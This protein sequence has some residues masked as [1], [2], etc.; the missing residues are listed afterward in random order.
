MTNSIDFCLHASTL[1][2]GP[3]VKHFA[4]LC[5]LLRPE[6]VAIR[7]LLTLLQL[8]LSTVQMISDVGRT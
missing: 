4:I 7:R 5:S 3:C 8:Y 6:V 1:A 2:I